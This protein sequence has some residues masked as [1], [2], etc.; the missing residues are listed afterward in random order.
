MDQ[1]YSYC[2]IRQRFPVYKMKAFPLNSQSLLDKSLFKCSFVGIL[3][4]VLFGKLLL[5]V[6]VFAGKKS[7]LYLSLHH[8]LLQSVKFGEM[9]WAER[10]AYAD[11]LNCSEGV[12]D[13]IGKDKKNIQ[14]CKCIRQ[15]EN[16]IFREECPIIYVCIY[17]YVKQN[18]LNRLLHKNV[19]LI[20]FTCLGC[21]TRRS[22]GTIN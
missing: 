21:W 1:N 20:V 7:V 13:R 12:V 10:Y 3:I 14:Y 19:A 5:N 16:N 8:Y 15:M 18:N 17:I 11:F 6:T 4:Q 2:R 22:R 9:L